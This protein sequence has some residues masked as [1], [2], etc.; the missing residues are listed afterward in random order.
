MMVSLKQEKIDFDSWWKALV[1]TY[2]SKIPKTIQYLTDALEI[3][4]IRV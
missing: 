1:A 3:E 2:A 4:D